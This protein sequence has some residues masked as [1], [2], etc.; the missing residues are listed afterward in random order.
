MYERGLMFMMLMVSIIAGAGLMTVKDL[1]L[2]RLTGNK[3]LA[4]AADYLGPFLCLVLV[5]VTLFISI[6]ERQDTPY[7]HMINEEE[8]RAFVWV[9]ENVG[10][11]YDKAVLD[12]WQATP[13]AAIT[14]KTVYTWVHTAPTA[15]DEAVSRDQAALDEDRWASGC[16]SGRHEQASV[17]PEQTALLVV[18]KF[19]ILEVDV[20]VA[21]TIAGSRTAH[22]TPSHRSL[23]PRND[24]QP[25]QRCRGA[26]PVRPHQI[27][28][29]AERRP[30]L[31]K[32]LGA[33]GE[34]AGRDKWPCRPGS[35]GIL[36]VSRSAPARFG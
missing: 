14:G 6:P 29:K 18:E 15:V 11:E 28:Q 34:P 36:R 25:R 16:A 35:A 8:Y 19:R 21:Q 33:A 10:E 20:R 5:G 26:L 2:R 4:F 30:A 31:E 12:P 1:R 32:P 22:R 13:F 23:V 9:K 24:R 27:P 17:D 3:V 7:Y